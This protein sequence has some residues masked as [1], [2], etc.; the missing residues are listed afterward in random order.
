MKRRDVIGLQP[1]TQ[2]R[3]AWLDRQAIKN[4]ISIGCDVWVTNETEE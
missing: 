2:E 1:P 3:M 4:P